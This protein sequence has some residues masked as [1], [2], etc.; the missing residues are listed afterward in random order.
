MKL[1]TIDNGNAFD[2]GKASGDYAK[3]RDIY[4]EIFYEKLAEISVGT[5]GQSVLD[6]GTG[7][8]VLPRNMY[9][10]GA[11]WIGVDISANQIEYARKLS[12]DAGMDIE[13]AVSSAEDIDFPAE[14]FDAVTACQCFM[15]FD[16]NVLLPK[17]HRILKPDGHFC[18]LFMAW[19]PYE[20]PIAKQSEELVLKYNPAW[21]GGHQTRYELQVPPWCGE[22]F[23]PAN[24]I[25]FDCPVT[26]TRE[27]WHGRIKACRG[28][29]ASSLS[30]A[31]IAAWEQEHTAYLQTVPE[32][33]DIL[34]YVSIMDVKKR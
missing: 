22:L 14:T 5:K 27:S 1:K 4:P 18:I 28:I 32:V 33:F 34:H 9:R 23:E 17:I 26:F 13:Y 19:L 16:K 25:T 21:T 11:K 24:M 8:G 10:Y 20:S 7:T 3:F 29:G 2:W 15:Y 30:E 31:E 6:I 12:A